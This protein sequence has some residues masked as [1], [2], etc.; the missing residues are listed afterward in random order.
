IFP[1]MMLFFFNRLPSAL[2]WYYTVSNT[3]TLLLQFVIQTYIID[4]DKILAKMQDTRSKPKVKTKSKWQER[5]EQVMDSQKKVLELK[6][7]T[8]PKK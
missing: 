4:H 6:N 7:K 5:Y 2:T 3:I 1:F 8:Q